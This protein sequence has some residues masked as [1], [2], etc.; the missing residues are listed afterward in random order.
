L[1]SAQEQQEEHEEHKINNGGGQVEQEEH[2]EVQHEER[3]I[4]GHREEQG[5]RSIMRSI[6][7]RAFLELEEHCLS[8][9]IMR[10]M[11]AR[12]VV[13][14]SCALLPSPR[15]LHLLHPSSPCSAAQLLSTSNIILLLQLLISIH[16]ISSSF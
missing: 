10:S 1:Y 13:P 8:S 12:V 7:R 2:L 15:S 16:M 11:S 3:C 4:G 14:S 6:M 5:S 9:I